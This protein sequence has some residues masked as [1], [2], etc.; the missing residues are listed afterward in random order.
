MLSIDNL[1]APTVFGTLNVVRVGELGNSAYCDAH[2][3]CFPRQRYRASPG[4]RLRA[5]GCLHEAAMR[6]PIRTIGTGAGDR[7]AGAWAAAGGRNVR[8][9]RERRL[10]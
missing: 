3:L 9:A 5:P 7:K 10:P 8:A 1:A 6:R 4:E 2:M